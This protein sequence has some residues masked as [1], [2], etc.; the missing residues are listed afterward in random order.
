MNFSIE[1][2]PKASFSLKF[3][4]IST[5]DTFA[6]YPVTN[7]VG[8]INATRTNATWYS[9]NLENILGDL[10]NKYETFNLR[11]NTVSYQQTAAFGVNP[12]DR[13]VYFLISGPAWANNNYSIT[14]KTNIAGAIMGLCN[15][16]Q[17]VAT[18]NIYENSFVCTFRKQKLLDI[19]IQLLTLDGTAPAMNA[20]T[21]FPRVSF[22]FDILPCE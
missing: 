16:T 6:N 11:L 21:Q 9:I 19:N 18:A 4:D 17:N 12:Y 7:N 3:N 10:Y 1:T 22:F 14:R 2:T 5:S 20:A 13:L 15:F 8:T